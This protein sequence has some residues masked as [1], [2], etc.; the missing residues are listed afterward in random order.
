MALIKIDASQ[1]KTAVALVGVL[2]VAVGVTVVRLKPQ[3]AAQAA[4]Q[5]QQAQA[6]SAPVRVTSERVAYRARNPFERP[7]S[8]PAATAGDDNERPG[9]PP[10][11]RRSA[12]P[13]PNPWKSGANATIEPAAPESI[14]AV[15]STPKPPTGP[16][17]AAPDVA[18]QRPVFTLL[19]TVKSD[20][21]FSAVIKTGQSDIRVVEIADTLE[22]GFKVIR[23]DAER[24][25]LTD[26][27]VTVV[28]KRPQL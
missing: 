23:L 4:D 12:L 14:F 2:A 17:P 25:V 24:A 11:G 13:V 9:E 3:G 8:L 7:A 6:G 22:G 27:R 1:T 5:V 28:A 19:A 21:G 15:R 26:G 18:K 20:R 10:G 16:G